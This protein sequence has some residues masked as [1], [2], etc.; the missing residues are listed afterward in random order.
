MELIR[1]HTAMLNYSLH[2]SY[3]FNRWKNVVNV[4]IKKESGNSKI[5][6]L[7]VIHLYEA[8]Y[9]LML[10]AKWRDL[11]HHAESHQS[12]HPGQYG[13]RSGRD[14]KILVFLE[15]LKTKICY[16]SRKSLINFD[17]DASS[18]YDRIIPALASLIGQ[19]FGMHWNVIFVHATT[20]EET[21]YK[22][23]TSMVVL[24]KFYASCQAFPIYGTGQGSGNS[25]AIWC[26]VSLVLFSC[27]KDK[28][29]GAY[30]CTP[31]KK[32]SISLLMI[33]FVDDSTGQVNEFELNTQPTPEL[34][35]Q[36]IKKMPSCGAT[37]SGFWVACWNWI[38]VHSIRYT[39]ISIRMAAL[40]CGVG[41]MENL[42]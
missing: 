41:S 42:S 12:L 14:A 15:E 18:C 35:R 23:K 40:S 3:S 9:N 4:M 37:S 7:H 31:D 2:H 26:I 34:L 20:L 39:L 33:G 16:A 5:H 6:C 8:N 13:G 1:A 27:H 38:N 28:G 32:M 19:K 25:P 22:L 30:F 10:Q 29:H 11:I 36:I 17:N 21:K 24:D